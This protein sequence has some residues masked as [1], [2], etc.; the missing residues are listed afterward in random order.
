MKHGKT[1][2]VVFSLRLEVIFHPE[3]VVWT[4]NSQRTYSD[5]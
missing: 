4:G 5:K 1:L 2:M 3:C